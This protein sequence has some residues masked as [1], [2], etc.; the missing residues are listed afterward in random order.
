[1]KALSHAR[2]VLINRL[3]MPLMAFVLLIVIGR[4]SDLL[5]GQYALVM[6]FYFVMQM[7]PLLGLT[8]YVMREVARDRTQAGRYFTTIGLMSVVG[9][10]VVDAA[11]A[12]VLRLMAYPAAVHDAIAIVGVLI[13]PGILLFLAE[14]IFMSVHRTAPIALVAVVENVARVALSAAALWLGHGLVALFVVFLV[15]RFAALVAYLFLLRRM[16]IIARFGLP[17]PA[18][19]RKTLRLLPSFLVGTLLF[20]LF[21]RLDFFVLSVFEPVEAVGYYAVA[22]RPFEITTMMLTALLMAIFPWASRLFARSS[23]A[24]RFG[25]RNVILV[26]AAGLALVAIVGV[27]L[28]HDY[29]YLL[30]AKQ[31]PRPVV[32]AQLFMAAVILGGMDFVLSSLLHA[33][34][35]QGADTR[36]MLFG[37]VAQVVLL[38]SLVPAFGLHGAFA[39]KLSAT[40]LQLALKHAHLRVAFG[41]ILRPGELLKGI[42][43]AIVLGAAVFAALDAG[44][45]ARLAAALA[46]G[47]VALPLAGI[48]SGLLQP[49]RLLRYL[50]RPRGATDVLTFGDLVDLATSDLREH[51]RRVPRQRRRGMDRRLAAT[52][53]Y[54]VARHLHLNRRRLLA[55]AIT[56]IGSVATRAR[57]DPASSTKPE[58]G[59]A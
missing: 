28:A 24:F 57:I 21:S 35:R 19:L 2:Y 20:A 23:A 50:W 43:V 9:C 34:D 37:G 59:T 31:Y 29:V 18:L 55:R 53:F 14:I 11:A 26:F 52:L 1:V 44:W 56:V 41:P 32:L 33:S 7:V 58:W 12:G 5:L 6:T 8:S 16:E 51:A 25:A 3:A 22:Y 40:A 36:A 13:F 4:H 39:A 27:L 42:A 45:M 17:D 38:L 46:L 48:A 47:L 54:R 30:F 15:T 49:L 10:I